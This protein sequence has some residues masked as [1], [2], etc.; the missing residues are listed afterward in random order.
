M[1]CSQK[2]QKSNARLHTLNTHKLQRWMKRQ[3]SLSNWVLLKRFIGMLLNI[4]TFFLIRNALKMFQTLLIPTAIP[5]RCSLSCFIGLYLGICP[6][7]HHLFI[8]F[9]SY[10]STRQPAPARPR[11]LG[12]EFP[13][14]PYSQENLED[15]YF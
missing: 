3:H 15:F 6:P 9:L 10:E 14:S 4:L 5:H 11:P 13:S 2:K 1:H 7:N 8:H 12:S